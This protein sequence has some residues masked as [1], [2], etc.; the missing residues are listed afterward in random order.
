MPSY[1]VTN[2]K[3]GSNFDWQSALPR[4]L[5][6]CGH[7]SSCWAST[8]RDEQNRWWPSN[9]HKRT[10]Y[11]LHEKHFQRWIFQ[12]HCS[13]AIEKLSA[14]KI[15]RTKTNKITSIRQGHTFYRLSSELRR[16]RRERADG[17]GGEREKM[18]LHLHVT[19]PLRFPRARLAL[20]WKP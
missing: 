15:N 14:K 18:L 17:V 19:N 7:W 10:W 6:T 1:G 9:H 16:A 13:C 4:F 5:I 3:N 11:C 8:N 20:A 2:Q 12:L